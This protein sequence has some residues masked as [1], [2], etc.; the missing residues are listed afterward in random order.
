MEGRKILAILVLTLSLILCQAKV[1]EAVPMG[2]AFSYQGHL[3]DANHVANGEYD[4]QFKLFDAD[5]DGNQLGIDVN[6]PDVDVIDGYFT[7]LLDFNDPNAFNGD[8]RWLET[9]VR[10]GDSN[11]VNDFVTLSPRQEVTAVPYALHARGVFVDSNNISVG[12]GAGENN[13][14]INN[15][16]VG[17][18]AGHSNT[19]GRW[20]TFLGYYAGRSNTT[21][22]GN[23]AIGYRT[24][25]DNTTG[26]LNLAVGDSALCSNTT[27]YFNSA[28][29]SR[30]LQYNTT[31]KCNSAMGYEAL[32][33]STTGF[34][35]SAMGAYALRWLQTGS[36]N[37]AV[38]YQ[39]GYSSSGNSFSNNSLF[40]Y[41]AGYALTAG[42]NNI[43]IGYQSGD[44][45]TTGTDNIIIGYN[46]DTPAVDTSNFL[47]IG[48]T[49]YG[50]LNTGKVGIGTT[51]PG[52]KLQVGDTD[53]G[54]DVYIAGSTNSQSG[55]FFYDGAIPGGMRYNFS[56]D[57]LSIFT[58][59]STR[60]MIDSAGDV[61]IG[62]LAPTEKLDVDGTARL[63]G[64]SNGA[65]SPVVVDANGT[66]WKTVSSKRYKRN[67]EELEIDADAVLKLRPVSFQYKSSGQK[68]IGLIAEEVQEQL[69]DLVIY[70]KQGRP[71]AVKYDKVALYLLEVIKSQEEK[72]AALEERVEA[73]EKTRLQHQFSVAKEVQQ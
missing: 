36:Y 35:N 10:P 3:Y 28:A 6:K 38:G 65:G 9:V 68:D 69:P 27:G 67:I 17:N 4:F 13:T 26:F 1:S 55:L 45:I 52:A 58:S 34:G 41:R 29:G 54:H 16:F 14:G 72:I 31:G 64:I 51:S 53:V 23:S 42:G 56:T 21:A 47:N 44:S 39:A 7:V 61:G 48:G 11:D 24:L 12:V 66:L 15:T 59:G 19:T 25:Q 43:L 2:T 22:F 18:H 50:D 73:L 57:D 62:T 20:N 60:V 32:Q 70:D 8:S 5:S 33:Y 40:G 49:I 63:R 46:E 71:E 30:I 37:T